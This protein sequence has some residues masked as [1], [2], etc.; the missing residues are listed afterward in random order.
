[1]MIRAVRTGCATLLAGLVLAIAVGVPV[2]TQASAEATSDYKPCP[3]YS[4]KVD[5]LVLMDQS[6]SLTRLDKSRQRAVALERVG[7]ELSELENVRLAIV[8]FNAYCTDS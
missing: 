8:G 5:L 7:L 2:A 4:K 3:A 6:G 1:M